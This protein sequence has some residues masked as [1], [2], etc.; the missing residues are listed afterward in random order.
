MPRIGI[1]RPEETAK[2]CPFC[3][4]TATARFGRGVWTVRCNARCT[5]GVGPVLLNAWNIRPKVEGGRRAMD[6]VRQLTALLDKSHENN[7]KLLEYIRHQANE[8]EAAMAALAHL[9]GK[10]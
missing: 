4:G 3:G 1:R 6:R 7:V 2:P 9:E 10:S 8:L 5:Y